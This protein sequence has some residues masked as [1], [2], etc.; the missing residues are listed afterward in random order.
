[1]ARKREKKRQTEWCW[2]GGNLKAT[3]FFHPGGPLPGET[4]THR[5]RGVWIDRGSDDIGRHCQ[6]LA[7]SWRGA[8]DQMRMLGYAPV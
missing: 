8:Y 7:R 2:D 5:S 4:H 1:M 3:L 6:W